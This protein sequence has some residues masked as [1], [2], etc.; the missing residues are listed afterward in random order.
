MNDKHEQLIADYLAGNLDDT[1][2]T[3]VEE[4]IASGE[5]DF[6]EFRE[7]DSRSR[8]RNELEVLCHA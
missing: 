2:K 8:Q 1:G 7:L 3:K 4:L 6:M 5:I